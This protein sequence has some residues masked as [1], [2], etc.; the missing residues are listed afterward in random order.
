MSLP[1][2]KQALDTLDEKSYCTGTYRLTERLAIALPDGDVGAVDDP[3]FVEWLLAHGE[4]APYGHGGQT[5]VDRDVRDAHRLAARGQASV[6]GFDPAAILDEIEAV[7][8]PR[9][10]LQAQLTDVLVYPVDGK[11]GRHKDTP[12][13]PELVGT[14]IVGLPIAHTGGAFEIDDGRGAQ[15]FD[16]SGT[17]DPTTLPWVALFSDVDHEIKPVTSG[18]RVTLVYALFQTDRP[19]PDPTWDARRAQL[20]QAFS[21][22]ANQHAWPVMIACT[23]QVITDVAKTATHSIQTL[24]GFDRD[25]ADALVDAG[26]RVTVRSCICATPSEAA[27]DRLASAELYSVARLARP[28]TPKAIESMD[29]VLTFAAE[30]ESD[31]DED[32]SEYSLSPYILDEVQIDQWVIRDHAAATL[33]HEASCFSD[34]GYFGNEAY[35]ACIYTLAALEVSR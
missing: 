14:L 3:K 2:L 13:T 21:L 35:E 7:L 18:A 24:R 30:P 10:H 1:A 20:R 27:A 32:L 16:W 15:V 5:K 28:L 25:L 22:L 9:F 29:E 31:E 33:V 17:S 6:A 23:R 11:F 26:Y 8:S 19:R 4:R 12:R 34:T